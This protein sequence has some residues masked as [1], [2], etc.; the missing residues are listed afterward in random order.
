VIDARLRESR[1]I[2]AS[3]NHVRHPEIALEPRAAGAGARA[4]SAPACPLCG[5]PNNDL[6]FRDDGCALRVCANC[7]L[8]FVDP[9]PSSAWQHQQV[10]SGR[11]AEIEILDCARRREGEQL[12][13]GR[14]FASIAE[15]C[16]G[17]ASL[18]DVGCGTG[19]LLER[20]ASRPGLYRAG[21]E[22]NP[23]AAEFAERVTGCEIFRVPLED[24]RGARAFDVITLINVFSHIPSFDPMFRTLRALLAPRGK[25]ILRT[26]E[27]SRT[28][29]RWNQI[30]WGIPDD[31]HF[32]G[33]RTLEFICAR[34]GFA[35]ARRI[36]T[37]FEDELFQVSRWQ[38]MGRN[39]VQN[40]VKKA[41]IRVPGGL[42]LIRKI[43]T[44]CLGQR[45]FVSF[46]VLTPLPSRE[47]A[48]ENPCEIQ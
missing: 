22:L 33:L 41:A 12:Y 5:S 24:F 45:L 31:L 1:Q 42:S 13:Y 8:F 9:Y 32:L 36:R 6:A 44:S 26:S 7:E 14:H 4:Y 30:H 28:V 19:H 10:S 23:E 25:L 40:A 46:L 27:M 2:L 18:L 48:H 38:Q 35:I 34:Y 3:A 47:V 37:P 21:I 20:F 43:Y 11:H 15:E 39:R 17:A 16:I 29:S